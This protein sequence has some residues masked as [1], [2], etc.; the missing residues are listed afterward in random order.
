MKDQE[1]SILWDE[2]FY[3]GTEVLINNFNEKDVERLKEKEVS[4][5]FEK[6]LELREKP[7]DLGC[8]KEQLNAI[9][10]YVFGDIYP[11]A[12]EYRKV[13]MRKAR[14]TFYL[15]QKPDDIDQRLDE[16]FLDAEERLNHCYG[17][18]DFCEVLAKLYTSLI[19]YHPYREGNGRTSR[20]FLRE[21]SIQ[22]SKELGF[23]KKELDWSRINIQ[24]LNQ[25]I[26]VSHLF[27]SA[28][29]VLFMNALV[30]VEDSKKN[31]M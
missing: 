14:G 5:S 19:Y 29:A 26:E 30:D 17:K 16:L 12:G 13:N 4:C 2:Y 1:N 11:F 20:E 10:K 8:G 27:P 7:F 9:H 6:L 15:I 24:E 31:A 22:K 18:M 25:Y 21:F 23:G 3:P 28:T